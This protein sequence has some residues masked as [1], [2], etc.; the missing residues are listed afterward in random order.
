MFTSFAKLSCIANIIFLSYIPGVVVIVFIYACLVWVV[1][2]RS[3]QNTESMPCM[4][5]IES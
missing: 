5:N 4:N 1:E 3:S 2:I